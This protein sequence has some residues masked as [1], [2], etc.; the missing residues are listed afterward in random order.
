M[1]FYF[2]VSIFFPLYSNMGAA[3]SRESTS[4]SLLSQQLSALEL[5]HAIPLSCGFSICKMGT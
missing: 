5:S 1:H 3:R 2:S 4:Q